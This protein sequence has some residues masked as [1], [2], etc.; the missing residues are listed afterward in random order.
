MATR[1]GRFMRG[2]SSPPSAAQQ[3]LEGMCFSNLV[4]AGPLR[5]EPLDAAI[6]QLEA[7]AFDAHVARMFADTNTALVEKTAALAAATHNMLHWEAEAERLN[8]VVHAQRTELERM[9][10]I[11]LADVVQHCSALLTSCLMFLSATSQFAPRRRQHLI[12]EI[13][14]AQTVADGRLKQWRGEL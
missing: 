6:R 10:R 13:T 4:D 7:E 14:R 9:R 11:S 8:A 2:F 5:P 3:I 1:W 12:E